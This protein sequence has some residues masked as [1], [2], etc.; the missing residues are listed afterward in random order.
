[1]RPR[2][3]QE[4][5]KYLVQVLKLQMQELQQKYLEL[6]QLEA[7]LNTVVYK[8]RNPRDQ[9]SNETV[10]MVKLAKQIQEEHSDFRIERCRISGLIQTHDMLL[11]KYS[12]IANGEP[13]DGRYKHL[14]L[15]KKYVSIPTEG[16]LLTALG[17]L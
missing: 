7:Q 14:S 5:A 9:S 11:K 17:S 15:N 6:E 8:L 4:E 16:K 10:C 1:M 3:S 2:I 13:H 12:A